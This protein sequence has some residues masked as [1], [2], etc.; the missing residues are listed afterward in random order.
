MTKTKRTTLL[1]LAYSNLEEILRDGTTIKTEYFDVNGVLT[2]YN[3]KRT[4][5]EKTTMYVLKQLEQET[6]GEQKQLELFPEKT[7]LKELMSELKNQ[8]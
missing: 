3:I 7:T 6:W 1:K 8:K 2:G 4:I 5:D